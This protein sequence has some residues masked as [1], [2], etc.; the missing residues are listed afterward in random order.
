M[1]QVYDTESSSF[2]DY[3]GCITT[4]YWTIGDQGIS[5]CYQSIEKCNKHGGILLPINLNTR[6]QLDLLNR[7]IKDKKKEYNEICKRYNQEQRIKTLERKLLI[8]NIPLPP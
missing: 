5:G 4:D 8:N 2:V 1:A 3:C 6:R 7:A